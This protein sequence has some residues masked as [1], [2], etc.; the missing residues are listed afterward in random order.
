MANPSIA[1][2]SDAAGLPRAFFRHWIHSREED[3]GGVEVYRPE[4]F[5][6]PPSFGRDG[7]EPRPDGEFILYEIGPADGTVAVPGHWQL[8]GQRQVLVTFRGGEQDFAFEVV[9]LDP[10][11]LR[12]R[13]IVPAGAGEE[14]ALDGEQSNAPPASFRLINYDRAEVIALRTNPAR[15]VLQVS[16]VMP[17]A[18]MTVRLSPAVYIRQPEYW[19]I[20]VTGGLSGSGIPTKTPYS[21]RMPLDSALGSRGI[22]VVGANR[23]ERF[24]VPPGQEPLD[25]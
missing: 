7:F 15:Y 24:D 9:D 18:G 22:Q 10:K 16:G 13:R 6:F 21:V 3:A 5:P 17:F 8:R 19:E 11:V 2:S 20:E 23:T 12:I 14:P 25:R 1:R 4:E